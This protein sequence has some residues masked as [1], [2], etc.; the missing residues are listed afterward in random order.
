MS[1]KS[2]PYI[3]YL[4]LSPFI[5]LFAVFYLYPVLFSFTISFLDYVPGRVK[6]VKGIN[7]YINL[8]TKDFLF[9]GSLKNIS[10]LFLTGGLIPHII[11]LPLSVILSNRRVDERF[12]TV[13]KAF[14]MIPYMISGV[15]LV[16]LY[17]FS[18]W[19][20]VINAPT[21]LNQLIMSLSPLNG[22]AT[23]MTLLLNWKF[24]GWN[25]LLYYTGIIGIPKEYY[26]AAYIEGANSF[27][28]FV[29]ITLQLLSP[30]IFFAVTLTILYTL[31]LFDEP[32]VFNRGYEGVI[33]NQEAL[34][35]A[36][37]IMY[38][39]FG[40]LS[41]LGKASAATWILLIIFLTIVRLLR[42]ISKRFEF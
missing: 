38:V 42:G 33:Y 5:I 23:V 3:P 26:E 20:S 7:Y 15:G 8:L 13:I 31:Q 18:S 28:Q 14:C 9:K 2:K 25:V 36:Y 32:Y 40:Q 1:I 30:I 37:Y 19:D 22:S 35:P 11:A 12:R 34:T 21:P 6:S 17:S 16:I 29:R 4:L 24:L 10:V 41:K 39:A 27:Q